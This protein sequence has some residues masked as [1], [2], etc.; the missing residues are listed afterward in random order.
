MELILMTLMNFA[1]CDDGL[2][3]LEQHV[4]VFC[5]LSAVFE[6]DSHDIMMLVNGFYF[7]LLISSTLY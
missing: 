5:L 4:N 1:S 6:Y 3:M 7:T 2:K